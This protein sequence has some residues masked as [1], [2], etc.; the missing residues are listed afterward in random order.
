MLLRVALK[1]RGQ[2]GFLYLGQN[3]GAGRRQRTLPSALLN[4]TWRTGAAR[5]V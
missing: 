2:R 3:E 4:T 5:M 1:H